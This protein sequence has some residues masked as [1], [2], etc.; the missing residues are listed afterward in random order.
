MGNSICGWRGSTKLMKRW[1]MRL[2]PSTAEELNQSISSLQLISFLFL[3]FSYLSKREDKR[4]A[5]A[6]EEVKLID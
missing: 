1:V 5:K 4:A 2:R 3:A 6:I